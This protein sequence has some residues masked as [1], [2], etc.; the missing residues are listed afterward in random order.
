MRLSQQGGYSYLRVNRITDFIDNSTENAHNFGAGSGS[1][2]L[3]FITGRYYNFNYGPS[4][5]N[6]F[7]FLQVHMSKEWTSDDQSIIFKH[8]YVNTRELFEV[9][10]VL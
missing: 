8:N 4:I 7:K 3:P 6:D 2:E 1:L 9:E 5:N 10:T